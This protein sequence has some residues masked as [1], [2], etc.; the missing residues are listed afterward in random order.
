MV[1]PLPPEWNM[2]LIISSA[3]PCTYCSVVQETNNQ[4][5]ADFCFRDEETVIGKIES[6]ILPP[7]AAEGP[8][9]HVFFSL[10]SCTWSTSPPAHRHLCLPVG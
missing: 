7:S 4:G 6:K 2:I 10:Q 9:L 3:T 8:F 5:I 1:V